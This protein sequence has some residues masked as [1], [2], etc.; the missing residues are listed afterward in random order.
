MHAIKLR[1]KAELKSLN[2]LKG[3]AK[4]EAEEQMIARHAKEIA[5]F[6]EQKVADEP[7]VESP[8]EPVKPTGPSRAQLRRRRQQQRDADALAAAVE[9][10]KDMKDLRLEEMSRFQSILGPHGLEVHEI[11]ADGHCMFRA[12]SHQYPSLDFKAMRKLAADTIESDAAMFAEFLFD[13]DGNPISLSLLPCP[14][15]ALTPLSQQPI[16]LVI[17]AN[18]GRLMVK[19]CGVVTQSSS[20]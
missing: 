12:L 4:K 7:L 18:C 11:T 16:F 13:D 8:V 2:S 10:S 17:P 6:Q 5:E 14:V 1:H 15:D 20:L 19:S 9:E 3:K